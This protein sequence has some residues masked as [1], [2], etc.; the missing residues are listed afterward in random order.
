VAGSVVWKDAALL[1]FG[2]IAGGYLGA[3]VGRRLRRETAERVVVVIGLV[4]TAALFLRR[5]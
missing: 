4:M 1:A 5:R 3:S 2:S